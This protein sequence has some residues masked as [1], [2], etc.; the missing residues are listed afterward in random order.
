MKKGDIVK[1]VAGHDKDNYYIVTDEDN[2]VVFLCDGKNKTLSEPKK[3]NKKHIE[4]TNVTVDL[5]V[6]NP[7]YDAHIRKELKSFNKIGG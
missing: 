2:E 4:Y 1:S 5:S 7:L 6:Y 3:K